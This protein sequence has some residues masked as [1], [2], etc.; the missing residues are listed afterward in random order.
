M[1]SETSGVQNPIQKHVFRRPLFQ[2][3]REF[4]TSQTQ[5]K[6]LPDLIDFNYE[7]NAERLFAIQEM[8]S[9]G[10]PPFS[11]SITF[12][13]LK[14]AVIACTDLLNNSHRDAEEKIISTGPELQS[15][16]KPVALFME[17]DVTL[18][19][20]LAALLYLDVP[21][22]LLS[23]RLGPIAIRHLLKSTAV[24]AIIVS[25]NTK[26]SLT[27]SL[28]TDEEIEIQIATPYQDL[29]DTADGKAI[30]S[31][32]GPLHTQ[33]QLGAIILHS[34]GTTGLPKPI[35]LSHRYMLAYAACHLLEPKQCENRLN[36]STLPLY[37][38]F[39][40]L[41][42]CISLST[43]LT[44]CFP[45]SGVIP[46]ATS[47][48][49]FIKYCKASSLMTV[50]TILEE[51]V[52]DKDYLESLKGLDFVAVGGGAIKQVTGEILVS[53]GAKLL[54][55]YGATELGPIAPI[56][57]PEDDYDWKY[58]RL[59]N[60]MEFEL[61]EVSQNGNSGQTLYQLVGYP[62]GQ[63]ECFVVQD[64][65]ERRP[66][67][68]K[69]EVRILGRGDDTIVLSIGEKVLPSRLE[70]SLLA[71][72]LAKAVVMFGQYRSEV[73][74]IVDPL[75]SIE[76]NDRSAF[77]DA[78]WGFI[79]QTNPLLDR[80]ARV[81][82]KSMIIIKPSNKE[83]P[84]SDK[85]SIMRKQTFELFE[86]EISD[87]YATTETSTERRILST[88][89]TRLHL[90]LRKLIQECVQDRIPDVSEWADDDDL[91]TKGMDSL[92]TTRLARILNCVSNQYAFPGIGNGAV[93]PGLIYQHP[94]IR[95]LA[96]VLLSGV[97]SD[98]MDEENRVIDLMNELRSQFSPFAD[99]ES[100][101]HTRWTILLTG[102]T[103]HLGTYLLQQLLRHPQVD[104]IICLIRSRQVN[105][106]S[107]SSTVTAKELHARQL[108]ANLKRGISLDKN[109]WNKI[110][111]LPANNMDEENLGLTQS[112]YNQVQNTVTHIIHNAWPMDFQQ[113]LTSFKSQIKALRNLIDFAADCHNA[114]KLSSFTNT[115]LLFVSS[116][117]VCAQYSLQKTVPEAPISDPNIPASF[118]YPQAKWVCENI[119]A[120]AV[121][122]YKDS[123]KPIILRLGQVVGSTDTGVWNPNEHFPAILKASQSVGTL[124][125]LTGTYSWI[126]V[127][128]AAK[129]L[130]EILFSDQ[131]SMDSKIVYHVENPIR[132]PWKSLLP[133]LAVK[134]NLKNRTPLPFDVW[135]DKISEAQNNAEEMES[136]RHLKQFIQSDFRKL[137]GELILDTTRARQISRS[138]RT[139]NGI[140]LDLLDK[141]IAYWRK[142]GQLS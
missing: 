121:E 37:H 66:G 47:V 142:C 56:F 140:T 96:D 127:D 124:P 119:L 98:R 72:G 65:L 43:G 23:I 40:F 108:E 97:N 33:D 54:N 126:P 45:S 116:I 81:S 32:K 85:G 130:L 74:V 128:V 86:K 79:Q 61:R 107:T 42:P 49:E 87:A 76:E 53:N 88:E 39:G 63:N 26:D 92:E 24:R 132:Q 51:I 131:V 9:A 31:F 109:S 101:R 93:K 71:C 64:F 78:I 55:H 102:S 104:K 117:A 73:G 3:S 125:D 129:S 67:T 100:K 139:T 8:R 16:K 70:D 118:G 19:V 90:D 7:H 106:S 10:K 2:V 20:Y 28:P 17:S 134:L 135:L 21:V 30:D 82:S 38:G 50:P 111:F 133:A 80:H 122:C 22:M 48:V 113:A 89:R 94:T 36:V 83:F 138:L 35:P 84:R 18:F 141:Y 120:D 27:R 68:E 77:I 110:Q 13:D 11:T 91:Y 112:E 44:C 12:K 1:P 69:L 5:L 58:L 25:S 29:L 95:A 103:G 60:D 52:A 41:A 137:S 59:R 123:V 15:Q 136:L 14:K 46:S 4:P 114:Q 75:N 105:L 57:C 6:T 99:V 115:R 62:F 34:S